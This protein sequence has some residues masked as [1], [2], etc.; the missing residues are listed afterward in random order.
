MKIFLIQGKA[1]EKETSDSQPVVESPVLE[2]SNL[3]QQPEVCFR[4]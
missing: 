1:E 4:I 2:N 3:E